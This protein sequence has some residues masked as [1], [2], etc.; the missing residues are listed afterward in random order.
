MSLDKHHRLPSRE[1]AY[2]YT[3]AMHFGQQLELNLRALL[4]TSDYHGW[5]TDLQ[6][7]EVQL[8]RFKD[9]DSFIDDAT[10]GAIISA[11]RKKGV[12]TEEKLL[13]VFERACKYRNRLAH[14]FLSDHDF[15]NWNA[16]QE[17]KAT[18]AI[19]AMTEDLYKAARFSRA[20]RNIAE[21][22]SDKEM[23]KLADNLAEFLGSNYQDPN[24]KY[25]TKIS[26]KSKK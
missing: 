3:V 25:A 22:H 12:I 7:T 8:R 14:N 18:A 15:D 11:I 26:K 23:Q 5:G 21:E 4:H 19:V 20:F 24:A 6:L 9:I 13:Q 16:Q 17:E 2:H 1:L 10:C